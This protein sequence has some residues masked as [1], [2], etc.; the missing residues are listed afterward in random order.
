MEE[1]K[2]N[3]F[4]LKGKA[5]EVKKEMKKIAEKIEDSADNSSKKI[6]KPLV[7]CRILFI[8]VLD[9][10]YLI[11]LILSLL[12]AT[13]VCFSGDLSSLNYAFGRRLFSYVLIL[14]FHVLL[15][16]LLNWF[17]KC[18]AKTM[19]CLTEN[20]VYFEH[21]IPFKR[22]EK[23]VPLNK[24]TKVS[25]VD[26]FWI[27]RVVIIHQ[28]LQMPK[29]FWT[30]NN[31]EFKNKLNELLTTDS[32]K[33]ENEFESKNI[34][35]KNCKKFLIVLGCIIAGIILLVGIG[36][37]F[38]YV[39]H[40]AR[41]LGGTYVNSEYGSVYLNKDDNTCEISGKI[42]KD[43]D[44]INCTWIYLE[45][46]D[47]SKKVVVTYDYNYKSGRYQYTFDDEIEFDLR[48]KNSIVYNEEYIFEKNK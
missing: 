42:S 47:D 6:I 27:F 48:D 43:R 16:F 31:H 34:L 46:F 20:E 37:F 2:N 10:I 44:V 5:A 13:M 28:Y 12:G 22:T 15:Y 32:G 25:T 9:K 21:Y 3:R 23:S 39:S 18:S 17:Y 36:R 38:G 26:I 40:P 24:I 19:L 8:S 1:N 35:P 4:D 7:T 33:V 41:H 29:I 30:W 14:I 45:R 11:S